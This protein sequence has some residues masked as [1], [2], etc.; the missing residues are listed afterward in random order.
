M[1]RHHDLRPRIERAAGS[2]VA[3]L[4]HLSG[5]HNATLWTVTLADGRRLAAKA[6]H[7]LEPEGFMLRYL[8]AHGALPVPAVHHGDDGLLLMDFVET[9]GAITPAAEEHAAELVAALH[10]VTAPRYGFPRSTP[11]GP[12]PQPNDESN[13][14][15]AFF[16]DRRLLHMARAALDEHRID[17]ALMA[18]IEALAARLP[19]LIGTPAPPSLVHGDLWT[20]NVLVRGGRVAAFIDPAIHHADPEVELAFTTLFGTFGDAFF[21]RYGEIRPLRPGFFEARRDLYNLYPL[22]V[23]V[24]LFGGSYVGGVERTVR[25]F[26]G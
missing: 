26:V 1:E 4:H 10:A 25:R 13:D 8:A 7:G 9:G 12:L 6:G 22:L 21:R 5:G 11:I 17:S 20:G 14:W 16:R 18:R 23:H 2:P 15:I 19:A 3:A 24:R